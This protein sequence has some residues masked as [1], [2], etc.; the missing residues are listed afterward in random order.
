MIAEQAATMAICMVP[1]VQMA[2]G[3]VQEV[4][5]ARQNARTQ[6]MENETNALLAEAERATAGIDMSKMTA[7][8]LRANALKCPPPPAPAPGQAPTPAAPVQ[9]QSPPAQ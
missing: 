8:T 9:P 3:V 6:R 2:C 7:I 5:S 4:Q 1:G